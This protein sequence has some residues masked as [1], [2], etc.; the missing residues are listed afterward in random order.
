FILAGRELAYVGE[1]IAMVVADKRYIAEDALSLIAVD[2]EELPAAS[3]CRDA[4]APG[5]P[6][7]HVHRKGNVL[8]DFVQRY[9]D[10]DKAVAAAPHKLTV[11]LKQHRGGAHPIETRGLV[12]SFDPQTDQ[13][14]VF[15][16]TQL[17]HECRIFIMKLLRL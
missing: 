2:I 14:T 15:S 5:A 3:D 13:L 11:N 8:I 7:V 17:A 10:A 9:G 16:S 1:A 4:F 12:A 6:D